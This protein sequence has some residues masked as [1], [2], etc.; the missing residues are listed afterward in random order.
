MAPRPLPDLPHDWLVA[1]ERPHFTNERGWPGVSV[2][3]KPRP[4]EPGGE[5]DV[6]YAWTLRAW[7]CR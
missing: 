1:I 5:H 6:R 4:W 2:R 3:A 7:P